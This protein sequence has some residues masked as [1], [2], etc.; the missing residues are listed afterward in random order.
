MWRQCVLALLGISRHFGVRTEIFYRIIEYLTWCRNISGPS[1]GDRMEEVDFFNDR[2][3]NFTVQIIT[4]FRTGRIARFLPVFTKFSF[5]VRKLI[6]V[7]T[8]RI[9]FC[10]FIYVCEY[11]KIPYIGTGTY[12]FVISNNFWSPVDT[13]TGISCGIDWKEAKGT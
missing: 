9:L 12:F 6:K 2:L 11:N 7:L 4:K 13:S 1:F 5:L 3:T 8:C 10:G